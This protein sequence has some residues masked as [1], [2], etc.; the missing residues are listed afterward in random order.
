MDASLRPTPVS[1]SNEPVPITD[2]ELADNRLAL[3]AIGSA[4]RSEA[5]HLALLKPLALD[6]GGIAH[7]GGVHWMSQR[8]PGYRCL[9]A[10]LV[11]DV[12]DAEGACARALDAKLSASELSRGPQDLR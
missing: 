8:D 1:E 9:R 5:S 6:A 7:E 12:E 3:A 11:G 4:T 2:A 10:Y